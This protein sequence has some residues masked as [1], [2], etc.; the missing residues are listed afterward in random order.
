MCLV[1]APACH[2]G[3]SMRVTSEL[4]SLCVHRETNQECARETCM[5][6]LGN[7]RHHPRARQRLQYDHVGKDSPHLRPNQCM[8]CHLTPAVL[9]LCPDEVSACALYVGMPSLSTWTAS[10]WSASRSR[11]HA[12]NIQDRLQ[13][14]HKIEDLKKLVLTQK[15][16]WNIS[17]SATGLNAGTR[18]CSMTMSDKCATRVLD[19]RQI[20]TLFGQSACANTQVSQCCW[21]VSCCVQACKDIRKNTNKE[22]ACEMCS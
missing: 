14:L 3:N 19:E 21:S 22:N 1:Q 13:H 11:R 4:H 18:V 16:E 5:L 6:M 15:M 2:V 10:F 8:Q 9:W 17:S 12:T 20:Q 7:D